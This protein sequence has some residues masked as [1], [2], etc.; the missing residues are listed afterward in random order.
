MPKISVCVPV[1]NVEKYIGRC[2]DSIQSQSFDDIEIIIVNDCTQDKSMDIIK[3]YSEKDNRI[4][5]IEHKERSKLEVCSADANTLM[6]SL[7][8]KKQ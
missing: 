8:N 2:I 1:Y 3:K 7:K 4:K 5:I 6:Q